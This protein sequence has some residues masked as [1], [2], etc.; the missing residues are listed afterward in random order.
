MNRKAA[1]KRKDQ[2][3]AR[4]HRD[5]LLRQSR[6]AVQARRQEAVETAL[7]RYASKASSRHSP[8]DD[9]PA[10]VFQR[11]PRLAALPYADAVRRIV[12]LKAVRPLADWSPKGKG[13]ETLFRSLGEHLLARYPVPALLWAAFFDDD[14]AKLAPL[15]AHVGGGGSLFEFVNTTDFPVPLTRRMCHDLLSMPSSESLL[16]AIRRVQ[17]RS[18]GGDD[19]LYRAWM[20]TP[21]ARA[22][23]ERDDEVF[24]TTVLGWLARAKTLDPSQVAPLVDFVSHRRRQDRAFSMAGRSL[25]AMTRAVGEWH[26]ELAT[27]KVIHGAVFEPSGYASVELDRSLRSRDGQLQRR[28][29]RVDEVRTSKE[30]AAEGRRM[31][32]CVYSYVW[33]IQKGQ[34][35]I[36]SMTLEDGKGETGRWAMLTIEVRKD[37]RRVVQARGRF[38]RSA[39]SEEHGILLAWAG[40]NGLEVSL[41]KWG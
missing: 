33:C 21:D 23:G 39:T 1:R 29:W 27:E 19:R 9:L 13:R 35:S 25:V 11:A 41:G 26:R 38:N 30:L 3:E 32:H 4:R 20:T 2:D 37:L 10:I 40:K 28:I 22:L 17:V 8:A 34:T 16:Q 18:A 36:W 24:W 12:A 31:N 7:A 14:A 15:V 5:A 6:A